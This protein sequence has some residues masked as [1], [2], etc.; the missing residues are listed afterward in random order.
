MPL[1]SDKAYGTNAVGTPN[2]DYCHHCYHDGRFIDELTVEQMTER[3]LPFL[4]HQMDV[5]KA[6]AYLAKKLPTLKRWNV[7]GKKPARE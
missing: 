4:E 5:E 1:T 6:R 3:C 7:E 2:P